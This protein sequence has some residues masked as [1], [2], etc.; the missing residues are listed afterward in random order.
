MAPSPPSVLVERLVGG[1]EDAGVLLRVLR[2]H[3]G[4]VG[5]EGGLEI[6]KAVVAQL[7]AVADERAPGP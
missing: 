1:D 7:G 6:A 5:A 3:L 4:G 2:V